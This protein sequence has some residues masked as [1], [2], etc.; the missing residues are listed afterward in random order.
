MNELIEV[1]LKQGSVRARQAARDLV[2]GIIKD[3]K[4]ASLLVCNH[5]EKKV[6]KALSDNWSP[7]TMVGVKT[8]VDYFEGLTQ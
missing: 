2:C 5:I 3:Q 7:T 4:Q 1:A 6:T 8:F